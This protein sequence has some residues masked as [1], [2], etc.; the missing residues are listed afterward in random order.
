MGR[1]CKQ[2]SLQ[3]RHTH[4]QKTYEKMLYTNNYQR[5]ANQNY[6]KVSSSPTNQNGHHQKVYKLYA[7][8]GAGERNP[9]TLLVGMKVGTTTMENGMAVPRKIKSRTTI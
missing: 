6:N 2:T 7:G 1:R 9:P 4:S 3:T 8:E 5:N